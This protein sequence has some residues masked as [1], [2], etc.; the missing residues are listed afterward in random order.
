MNEN[1]ILDT[2]VTNEVAENVAEEVVTSSG[3][4]KEAGKGAL[5]IAGFVAVVK[6]GK[7][8]WKKIKNAKAKAKK[9]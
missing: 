4:L 1:E 7:W 3:F 5:W 2:V 8:F 9:E 6:G